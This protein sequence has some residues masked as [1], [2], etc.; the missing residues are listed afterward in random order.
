MRFQHIARILSVCVSL[1]LNIPVFACTSAII[2]AEMNPSGRPILWKHRDT[3]ATDNKVEYVKGKEGEYSFVALFNSKDKDLSQAWIGMNEAGF[4]I[5]NTVSYNLKDDKVPK[6]KMDREG[7]LMA[8]ALKKC[9]TVSDFAS[10][11]DALTRP[12]GVETNFG[13]IDATG[14]GA[15]FETNNHSYTRFDLEDA[16]NGILIRTNFSESGRPNQGKGYMREKNARAL[17]EPYIQ[18]RSV[19]PEV[20]TEK[21]SRSFF[22]YG[23]NKDMT[24][25]SARFITGDDFIPR[26]TSVATVAIEGCRPVENIEEI[27]PKF[28]SSEYIMWTGIGYPPCAEI[29]AVWCAPNGVDTRLRGTG[30]N[31]LSKACEDAKRIKN[32]LFTIRKPNKKRYLEVGKLYNGDETGITQSISR[33]NS[34]VYR[35]NMLKRDN[36]KTLPNLECYI[37]N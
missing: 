24:A 19:T 17:L 11:L 4:A 22:H 37:D 7:Y 14:N 27:T 2:S 33:K 10:F 21:L 12:M 18:T 30:P 6:S 8:L 32:Q 5:M 9:R 29:V 36:P 25:D 35:F 23:M 28:I 34:K 26:F 13:V 31:G 3:S 1:L 20:L 15:Y 16:E